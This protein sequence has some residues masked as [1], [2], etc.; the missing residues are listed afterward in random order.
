MPAAGSTGEAL[1]PTKVLA[2]ALREARR[3]GD[4]HPTDIVM[5]TGTVERASKVQD[6]N[7]TYMSPAEA[8][9]VAYL[10]A[11]HGHFHYNG[12]QPPPRHHRENLRAIPVM[13]SMKTD[14]WHPRPG[15]PRC[16]CRCR[17]WDR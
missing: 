10:V 7:L 1:S 8:N 11:M 2:I 9:G 3:S 4:A 17:T 15:C 16:R 14:S 6:P 13:E 5:A 12:P